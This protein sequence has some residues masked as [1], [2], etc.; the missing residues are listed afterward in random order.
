MFY[1]WKCVLAVCGLAARRDAKWMILFIGAML[2]VGSCG[3]VFWSVVWMRFCGVNGLAAAASRSA[4]W[5]GLH[6]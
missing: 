5:C 1:G 2:I 4:P 3:A 6:G